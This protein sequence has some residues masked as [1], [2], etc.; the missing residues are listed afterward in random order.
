MTLGEA[1]FIVVMGITLLGAWRVVASNK[2]MHAALWL[3]FTFLG[4]ATSFLML[5]ADFVAAAQVLVYVGAINTMIVF[6]VMLS[7]PGELRGGQHT[8]WRRFAKNLRFGLLPLL[9]AVGFGGVMFYIYRHTA[10]P[11][12][13]PQATVPTDTTALLGTRLFTDYV[14]PFEV[15]SL[16]LLVALVGA[17][18]L[19][20][21]YENGHG[22][23]AEGGD[24]Q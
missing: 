24:K 2:I 10:W 20:V 3:G 8:G 7:D 16:I 17:I 4:V 14:V 19:A 23:P 15:A 13:A 6:G 1:G 9:T 21:T 11:Q 5:N 18:I 22:N 12:A